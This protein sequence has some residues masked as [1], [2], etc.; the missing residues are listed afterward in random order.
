MQVVAVYWV[1]VKYPG[2]GCQVHLKKRR[3]ENNTVQDIHCNGKVVNQIRALSDHQL[4]Q[5]GSIN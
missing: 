3:M 2:K 4:P 1:V 5:F